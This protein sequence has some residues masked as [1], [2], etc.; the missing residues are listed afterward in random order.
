MTEFL[1]KAVIDENLVARVAEPG[2]L[3]G[4][5]RCAKLKITFVKN[6]GQNSEQAF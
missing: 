1:L 3:R 2:Q 5:Q 4:A 6:R